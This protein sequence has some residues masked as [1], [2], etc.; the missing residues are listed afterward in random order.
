M[1]KKK[2]APFRVV[3]LVFRGL[4]L[5]SCWNFENFQGVGFAYAL[6]LPALSSGTDEKE[7]KTVYER[8]MKYFNTNPYMAGL[9]VGGVVR[10][11]E[12]RL[13]GH[14]TSQQIETF[15]RDLMAALGA[16]GD[17]LIW[18][19]LRPFAGLIGVMAA[20]LYESPAPLVFLLIYN[21]V[22]LWIRLAGIRNGYAYGSDILQYLKRLNLQRQIFWLN[23]LILFAAGALL[24]LWVAQA[25]PVPSFSFF[26]VCGAVLGV[27]YG[28]WKGEQMRVPYLAQVL[29]LLLLSQL[30]AHGGWV[31]F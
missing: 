17:S 10:L 29:V 13:A 8:H 23:G 12:E 21:G 11:E 28:V 20:L 15:K 9:I 27:I 18:G 22:T 7:V 5:Q 14:A 6:H 30:L 26:A 25:A 4:F 31:S 16:L 1:E 3:Q 19:T 24:P 2:L